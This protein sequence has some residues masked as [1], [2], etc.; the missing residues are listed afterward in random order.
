MVVE[1]SSVHASGSMLYRICPSL[2]FSNQGVSLAPSGLRNGCSV[3]CPLCRGDMGSLK[4][5][6][7]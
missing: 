6:R 1:M 5:V 7:S 3:T 2:L 4:I